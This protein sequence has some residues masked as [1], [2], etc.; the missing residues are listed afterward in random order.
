MVILQVPLNILCLGNQTSSQCIYLIYSKFDAFCLNT[1]QQ[2][3]IAMENGPCE[4][5]FPI[6]NRDV[7]LLC[8][9]TRGY[10]A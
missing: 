10:S 8:E 2:T 5:V 9:F 7:P 1:L 3:N 4:D 6:E